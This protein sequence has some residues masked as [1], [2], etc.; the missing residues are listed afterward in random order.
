MTL[1]KRILNFLIDSLVYFGITFL[2][3][4]ISSSLINPIQARYLFIIF[5]FIYYLV[6]EFAFGKTIGKFITQTK[7][8]SSKDLT[9][10][11][12]S[13]IFIRTISRIIPFYFIS[14]LMT[15]KGMHDHFSKTILIKS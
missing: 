3:I 11:T 4:L 2:T 10:P 5:Y 6:F 13:Q 12:F 9:K 7:V 15:G 8:V 14:Y 1:S